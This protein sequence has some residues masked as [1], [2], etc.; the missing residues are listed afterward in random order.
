MQ[1]IFIIDFTSFFSCLSLM[2]SVKCVFKNINKM[3]VGFCTFFIS[4]THPRNFTSSRYL[5]SNLVIQS[6]KN[7]TKLMLVSFY[8]L[9]SNFQM[10]VSV[11]LKKSQWFSFLICLCSHTHTHTHTHTRKL[12]SDIEASRPAVNSG[13]VMSILLISKLFKNILYRII[14]YSGYMKEQEH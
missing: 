8:F 7:S 11:S 4:P 2:R 12:D 1:K 6:S 3:Q 13:S 14:P 9:N 5:N 10:C